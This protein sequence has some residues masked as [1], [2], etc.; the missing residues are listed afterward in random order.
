MMMA[1]SKRYKWGGAIAS[2]INGGGAIILLWE[3]KKNITYMEIEVIN[4]TKLTH[5]HT[6]TQTKSIRIQIRMFD[7]SAQKILNQKAS[8][9]CLN[10]QR[11]NIKH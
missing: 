4:E 11:I 9:W 2:I 5:V 10:K 8:R 1:S 6:P 7:Y 3:Y